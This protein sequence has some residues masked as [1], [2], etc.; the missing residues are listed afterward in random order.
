MGRPADLGVIS[1]EATAAIMLGESL[2]VGEGG[3]MNDSPHQSDGTYLISFGFGDLDE[4]S[5]VADG[6]PNQ[7]PLNV[8]DQD[9]LV[10][11]EEASISEAKLQPLASFATLASDP[12]LMSLPQ[13]R[14]CTLRLVRVLAVAK[15]EAK[16]DNVAADAR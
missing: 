11:S 15:G 2:Q 14:L 13:E 5:E 7:D 1:S 3:S 10:L 6:P 8:F 12:R 16:L 9:E 4:G